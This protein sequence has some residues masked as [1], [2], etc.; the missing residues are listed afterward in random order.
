MAFLRGS[1]TKEYSDGKFGVKIC[2]CGIVRYTMF[3]IEI[4]RNISNMD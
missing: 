3:G 1:A 2:I 4:I